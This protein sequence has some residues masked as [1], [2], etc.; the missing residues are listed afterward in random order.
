MNREPQLISDNQG[1]GCFSA[2]RGKGG[3]FIGIAHGSDKLQ[4]PDSQAVI[5]LTRDSSVTVFWEA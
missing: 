4:R 2:E 3:Q 1:G 5:L